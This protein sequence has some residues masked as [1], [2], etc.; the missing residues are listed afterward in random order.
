MSKIMEAIKRTSEL[1][2]AEVRE[3]LEVFF[4]FSE[5]SPA[6]ENYIE[7]LDSHFEELSETELLN[8][9]DRMKN[10]KG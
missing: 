8:I 4:D 5:V 10:M 9:L 6:S 2:D 1:S 3:L 7:W